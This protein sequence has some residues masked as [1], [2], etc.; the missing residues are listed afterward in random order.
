MVWY[1]PIALGHCIFSPC[2]S[3]CVSV[4]VTTVGQ[5]SGWLTLPLYQVYWWA[6]WKHSVF[7]LLC[8]YFF[9]SIS[10][11]VSISLLKYSSVYACCPSSPWNPST[12]ESESFNILWVWFCW[13]F[14]SWLGF[15]LFFFFDVHYSLL[16]FDWMLDTVPA[17]ETGIVLK[18]CC[19]TLKRCR[20]SWPPEE[21]NSIWGQRQGLIAQSFCV[22]KFY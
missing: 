1:C 14:I 18:A 2:F 13:L 7:P 11:V 12:F 5:S 4:W 21:K 8:F 19:W 6:H 15:F 10:V 3:L 17:L 20:D 9:S 16:L 22:I